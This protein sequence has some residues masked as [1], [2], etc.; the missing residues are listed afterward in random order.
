VL[1]H[2]GQGSLYASLHAE[3]LIE[4]LAA[5]ADHAGGDNWTLALT[6][7]LTETGL[8]RRSEVVRHVMAALAAWEA[9]PFPAHVRDEAN[10]MA[11]T[12]YRFQSRGQA[13]DTVVRE[14]PPLRKAR[15]HNTHTHTH[16]HTHTLAPTHTHALYQI[17]R[18]P[19][20]TLTFDVD[21][22]LLARRD[23]RSSCGTSRWRH[24]PSRR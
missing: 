17:S 20:H 14:R 8:A 19:T 10:I 11:A 5:G 4:G 3:G 12:R 18:R 24:T 16:T 21:E 13:Y 1:G 6:L 9:R 2:E 15:T 23:W 7:T 22:W